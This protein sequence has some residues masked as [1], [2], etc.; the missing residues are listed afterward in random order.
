MTA[1]FIVFEGP[2]GGG[3][4]IQV[5]RL[6]ERLRT[7]GRDV[8][9]TRE[10]GGTRVGN[11]IRSVLLGLKDYAILPETEVLLLAAARAQHV[12]EVI[13]PAL[14]RGIWVVCD[15]YVDSTYAYQGGGSGLEVESL[16]SIQEFATNGLEPDTRI[17]LD[18]PVEIGLRRRHADP[19]TVNRIDMADRS[20]HERV[21]TRYLELAQAN[22]G[23]WIVIDAQETPEQV[24]MAIWRQLQLR[25]A[26]A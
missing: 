13:R 8:V 20:Y 18:L 12:R 16:R 24:E 17:L 9:S 1:Q 4:S 3:K 22:P 15:R 14:E 21:R 2:E 7:E 19:E 10:P 26:I 23:Q 11:D 5:A 6:V 25:L